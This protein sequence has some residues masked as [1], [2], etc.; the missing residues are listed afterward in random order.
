MA[1]DLKK[2]LAQRVA[3]TK[4]VIEEVKRPPITPK[5]PPKEVRPIQRV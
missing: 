4:D 1:K 3:K 2:L 5:A